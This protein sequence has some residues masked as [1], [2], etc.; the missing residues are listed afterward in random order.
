MTNNARNETILVPAFALGRASGRWWAYNI[1]TFEQLDELA[2]T[3]EEQ[4]A[5]AEA[6]E[7]TYLL[8][9]LSGALQVA[10]AVDV[11]LDLMIVNPRHPAALARR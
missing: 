1:A 4:L 5:R 3:R 8:G 6:E 11:V 2:A 9:Y 7:N 10:D